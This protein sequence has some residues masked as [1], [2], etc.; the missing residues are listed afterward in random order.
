MDI[1]GEFEE[2]EIVTSDWRFRPMKRAE[3]SCQADSASNRHPY[4]RETMRQID[5]ADRIE[6]ARGGMFSRQEQVAP[7]QP[8]Y[9]ESRFDRPIGKRNRRFEQVFRD[10]RGTRERIEARFDERG[11]AL[12]LTGFGIRPLTYLGEPQRERRLTVNNN[13]EEIEE[14]DDEAYLS[15]N[16]IALHAMDNAAMLIS[17]LAALGALKLHDSVDEVRVSAVQKQLREEISEIIAC[18]QSLA[19]LREQLMGVNVKAERAA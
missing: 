10:F 9:R 13:R 5:D 2:E 15:I 1:F 18:T 16:E 11:R 4:Q 14:L 12:I 6:S 17:E 19:A 8:H 7:A 3:N